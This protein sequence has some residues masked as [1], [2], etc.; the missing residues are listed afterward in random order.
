M[1]RYGQKR[2]DTK[3]RMAMMAAVPLSAKGDTLEVLEEG[4]GAAVTAVNE[5]LHEH[6][7]PASTLPLSCPDRSHAQL[8]RQAIGMGFHIFQ[9]GLGTALAEVAF[10]ARKTHRQ[11]SLLAWVDLNVIERCAFAAIRNAF[12]SNRVP[13]PQG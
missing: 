3:L 11:R 8:V 12:D 7:L 4:R 10:A 9:R 5:P 6:V 13:R 1:V 2:Q